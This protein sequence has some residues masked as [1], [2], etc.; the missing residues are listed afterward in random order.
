MNVVGVSLC[1]YVVCVRPLG[2]ETADRVGVRAAF[3]ACVRLAKLFRVSH[4][5]VLVD[6][7][8][9]SHSANRPDFHCISTHIDVKADSFR[10]DREIF[11]TVGGDVVLLRENLCRS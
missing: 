4:P 10:T 8:F 3:G 1:V 5:Y 6:G 7:D 2:H 9:R 11:E